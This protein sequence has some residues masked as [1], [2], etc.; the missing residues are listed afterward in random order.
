VDGNKLMAVFPTHLLTDLA[1]LGVLTWFKSYLKIYLKTL[2]NL[3]CGVSMQIIT[4]M[5][6]KKPKVWGKN[7]KKKLNKN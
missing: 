5:K 2:I 7:N 4:S 6:T 1:S 3:V